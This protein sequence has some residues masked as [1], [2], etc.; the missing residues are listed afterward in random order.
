MPFSRG[1]GKRPTHRPN[2]PLDELDGLW[3]IDR[4]AD[5]LVCCIADCQSAGR[6]KWPAARYSAQPGGLATR[7]PAGWQPALLDC[8]SAALCFFRVSGP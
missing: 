4:N 7:D 1:D 5:C 8:T 3:L 6:A 2:P